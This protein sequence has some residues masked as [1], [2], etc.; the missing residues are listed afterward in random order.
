MFGTDILVLLQIYYDK[1]LCGNKRNMACLKLSFVVEASVH[2]SHNVKTK[3]T[4]SSYQQQE[5]FFKLKLKL[6]CTA[7]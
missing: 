4:K 2:R 1:A 5:R 7:L 6:L 3:L